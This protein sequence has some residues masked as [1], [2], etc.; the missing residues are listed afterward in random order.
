LLLPS[1]CSSDG[2]ATDSC[3]TGETVPC[4]CPDG[5]HGGQVCQANGTVG[6]CDCSG[7]AV[8]QT[9]AGSVGGLIPFE[10]RPGKTVSL[11]SRPQVF[12]NDK[13][14]ETL[15]SAVFALKAD[16]PLKESTDLLQ[17]CAAFETHDQGR[18][19]WCAAH[20]TLGAMELSQCR[21]TFTTRRL[22]EP[23]LWDL[24]KGMET[25]CEGGWFAQL[26]AE[27]A[28]DNFIAPSETW[29]M[30]TFGPEDDECTDR[31][32]DLKD[33][34][35]GEEALAAAG[36]LR[37]TSY[38]TIAAG[39]IEA[40]KMALAAD[41]PVV[42]GVPVFANTGWTGTGPDRASIAA[43]TTPVEEP[44]FTADGFHCFCKCPGD[45]PD[46]GA[47]EPAHDHCL[48]GWHAVLV[49]GYDDAAERFR[50][51]N[52]WGENWPVDGDDGSYFMEY[53][54]VQSY[55]DGG[56]FIEGV[57]ECLDGGCNRGREDPDMPPEGTE[58]CDGI[59]ND[60]DGETDEDDAFDAPTWYEDEDQDG[61]GGPNAVK[62]CF[63]PPTEVSDAA[64]PETGLVTATGDCN[65]HK[66][67]VV[68][69]MTEVCDGKD[70]DCDGET[71]EDDADLYRWFKDGDDDGKGIAA[72]YVDS[73]CSPSEEGWVL[74]PNDCDDETSGAN[75]PDRGKPEALF[76][77]PHHD[78]F[79]HPGHPTEP[80]AAFGD[81]V[82]HTGDEDNCGAPLFLN[83]ICD[84]IANFGPYGIIQWTDYSDE[85]PYSCSLSLQAGGGLFKSGDTQT[86]IQIMPEP[87][88]K[89]CVPDYNFL[90]DD[91]CSY[92]FTFNWYGEFQI[93]DPPRE[94]CFGGNECYGSVQDAPAMPEVPGSANQWCAVGIQGYT[95]LTAG[96]G[97]KGHVG[98]RLD[99]PDDGTLEL[100]CQSAIAFLE[101]ELPANATYPNTTSACSQIVIHR[102]DGADFIE[103]A[104]YEDDLNYAETEDSSASSIRFPVTAGTWLVSPW[105]PQ[106]SAGEFKIAAEYSE[107]VAVTELEPNH[108][109]TSSDDHGDC[110]LVPLPDNALPLNGAV[111]GRLGY[112]EPEVIPNLP[113]DVFMIK[114]LDDFWY[115]ELTES[116]ALSFTLSVGGDLDLGADPKDYRE[117]YQVG[118]AYHDNCQPESDWSPPWERT[119][120]LPLA[121]I[122]VDEIPGYVPSPA[123][124][125]YNDDPPGTFG[126]IHTWRGPT[127]AG[128]TSFKSG[129]MALEPGQYY[130]YVGLLREPESLFGPGQNHGSYS[131]T[132]QSRPLG[133]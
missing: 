27:V 66:T 95:Y 29:P 31:S 85:Y 48:R 21:T 102:V 104:T 51:M 111:S 5:A 67:S 15:V 79:P 62:A 23:H 32:S 91:E 117:L 84:P 120:A 81:E 93:S 52:S 42:I 122:R 58:L 97:V 131:I 101:F 28:L 98:Y 56:I 26:A 127:G 43:V 113:G 57:E 50:F 69:G 47:C 75:C 108:L 39:D 18:F 44:P 74:Q 36:V 22:S 46:C 24:G 33:S 41:H 14:W 129:E 106:A 133:R 130:L 118:K 6:A 125:G 37:V 63:T 94:E 49:V 65:D 11:L 90:E 96:A 78:S 86:A 82:H 115:F 116:T 60:G 105:Y 128:H 25:P 71:D 132:T 2:E 30:P 123:Y 89:V 8:P 112:P 53:A 126:V 54:F 121:V 20:S 109:R 55:S 107:A 16:D 34:D 9:N 80:G 4:V 114:D 77:C 87:F 40:I 61:I 35:P 110:G 103:S 72:D 76:F 100:H 59:D 3:V 45:E 10:I 19:G 83:D 124:A 7:A 38:K 92:E 70:N 88:W 13:P 1:A 12:V 64:H 73:L 68:P 119:R 99:I 17:G